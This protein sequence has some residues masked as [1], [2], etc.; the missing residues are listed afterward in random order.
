MR[1]LLILLGILIQITVL[2]ATPIDNLVKRVTPTVAD[3]F[4]FVLKDGK[5]NTDYFELNQVGD[6]IQITGNNYISLATG[7]NWYLKHYAG[8]HYSWNNLTPQ[9]PATLPSVPKKEYRDTK[10]LQR[11][12]FNYCTFSYSM[13][14]WDWQRW[15]QELDWMAMH[16]INLSLAIVGVENVWMNVLT[17]LGYTREEIDQ[18]ISGPAFMA[19]WQ[20]NN[21]E[22]WGGPNTDNWYEHS[23][24]LQSK[25]VAR[26]HE[27]G[28]EPV[29]S[30][31]AGM[32]PHNSG[33]K[34]G[35]NVAE[36]GLWCGLT[37]P[38]FLQPTDPKFESIAN[39]YY[40]EMTK[41]YGK[42]NYYAVDPFHE[43]GTVEGVDLALA[44]KSILK[45]MKRVNPESTWVIQAWQANPRPQ[46]IEPIKK[47]NLLVLDLFSESRPMWGPTWSSWHRD[48]GYGK[49]NWI[50][51]MLLNFGGR[52]GMFGKMETLTKLYNETQDYKSSKTLKGVGATMEAIENNPIM[53]ELLFELPWLDQ[54]VNV[55]DWLAN[56]TKSRYGATEPKVDQAWD[57]LSKT[58]YNA[59]EQFTQEGTT[60]TVFA[61]L[62]ALEISQVSCC[63]SVHPFYN[64][65]SIKLVAQIL[66]DIAPKFK[67]NNNFE[68][69]LVDVVRQAVASK[70]YYLQKQIA[71]DYLNKDDKALEENSK[72]FLDLLM[73]QDKLLATQADF[74]LGK[75]TNQAR[76]LGKTLAEKNQ[77]EWNARTQITVWGNRESAYMLHNYAY[78]EWEGLLRDV[79][80]PRWRAFLTTL[81]TALETDTEP[82]AID[83]FDMDEKWTR[84]NN[85]YNDKAEGCPISTAKWVYDTYLAK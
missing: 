23:Y 61:A 44:G 40:D 50:F 54:P 10:H 30:G 52:S 31:Y 78:K 81:A 14:F 79:Y 76:S 68:H 24:N 58:I 43:G 64:T 77:Y 83:Y 85:P 25:I 47:G 65:D 34:L 74:R 19:W 2:N 80:Y 62:P 13:A 53:F 49:H 67:G 73:A 45:A 18:F 6:K 22:G 5:K 20:M 17:Q 72:L 84:L 1:K 71:K 41:L 28:I 82:I 3:Q 11:F 27:I 15:E 46:M 56:Y 55:N 35:L 33:D 37:R 66:L 51:N 21:M 48:E 59:P 29:Y 39:L 70:A 9:V 8:V 36:Q 4:S 38:S 12:Y 16:G 75:W 42:A 57:I 63:S 7:Y 69:D 26:M 32:L 60:E